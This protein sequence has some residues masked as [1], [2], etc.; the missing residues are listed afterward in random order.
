M[1]HHIIA[2]TE[3]K[4]DTTVKKYAKKCP[5]NKKREKSDSLTLK[6][7][8]KKSKPSENKEYNVFR[9]ITNVVSAMLTQ[10]PSPWQLTLYLTL[11]SSTCNYYK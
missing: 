5:E 7:D 9:N 2:V 1:A 8:V 6:S 3:H 11:L 10:I 4:L